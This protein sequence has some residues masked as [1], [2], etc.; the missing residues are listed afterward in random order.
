MRD[1]WREGAVVACFSPPFDELSSLASVRALNRCGETS[2]HDRRVFLALSLCVLVT[3]EPLILRCR[4][5]SNHGIGK[6]LWAALS[7]FSSF[8][9][10]ITL[11]A[12]GIPHSLGFLIYSDDERLYQYQIEIGGRPLTWPGFIRNES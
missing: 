11:L 3:P 12:L 1:D 7:V 2:L 5:R 8:L 9:F 6:D 10:S 4:E